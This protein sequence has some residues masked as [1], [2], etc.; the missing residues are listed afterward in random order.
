MMSSTRTRKRSVVRA[1]AFDRAP[2]GGVSHMP[3]PHNGSPHDRYPSQR[4]ESSATLAV[5]TRHDT[6]ILARLPYQPHGFKTSSTW[7]P[8]ECLPSR[9][10][11][12]T[13][14]EM[15][16]EAE[17]KAHEQEFDRARR[18]RRMAEDPA[19]R[20]NYDAAVRLL[21]RQ[22]SSI[23]V[24][25][26]AKYATDTAARRHRMRIARTLPTARPV[27][28]RDYSST[29]PRADDIDDHYGRIA[30]R[31]PSSRPAKGRDYISAHTRSDGPQQQPTLWTT[32]PHR[33]RQEVNT[34]PP[35][36]P[37]GSWKGKYVPAPGSPPP[38]KCSIVPAGVIVTKNAERPN[39]N[40]PRQ[41]SKPYGHFAS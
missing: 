34:Q 28:E 12:P 15:R 19:L 41:D 22:D 11:P 21:E 20:A 32:A 35:L 25:T 13:D 8:P 24:D 38:R 18:E 30:R 17:R 7:C 4:V 26:N 5:P 36:P 31:L 40:Q 29:R 33:R 2:S 14:E 27:E 16:A 23:D 37:A 9:F 10:T 1:T 3:E 39:R 6:E